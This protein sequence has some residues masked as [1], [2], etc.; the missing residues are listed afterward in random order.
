VERG[1]WKPE[2]DAQTDDQEDP[3]SP[4]TSRVIPYVEDTR[5]CLLIEPAE[6]LAEGQMASLQAALKNAIQ[7]RYQL[8]DNELAAE[9]LPTYEDRR[10]LLLYESAEGGAGV[11]RRLID[12]P[13][14]L[15]AVAG[16]AL[17]ICHF[18]PDGT[19][20]RRAPRAKEDC[21]AACYDCLM[22]YYNQGEHRILDR[23]LIRDELLRLAGAVTVESPASAPRASHLEQLAQQAES[24]LERRWLRYLDERGHRLPSHAQLLIEAAQTRPDFV[25]RDEQVAVY[26]DGPVHD[27]PERRERDRTKAEWLE[28]LGYTV[29]RFGHADEWANLLQRYPHVFGAPQYL[30]R[31]LATPDVKR[32]EQTASLDPDLFAPEYIPLLEAIAAALPDAVIE[33]GGDVIS[34]GRVAGSYFAEVISGDIKLRLIT[35]SAADSAIIKDA[36]TASGVRAILVEP[37]DLEGTIETIKRALEIK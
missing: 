7:V 11:L 32:T 17:E 10:L 20:K 24:D 21:E 22:S 12:D 29:I 36:I 2:A 26:I 31:P 14:A 33:P 18:E 1:Y 6:Q 5:N 8:E 16:K 23:K 3:L 4:R 15:A 35:N 28:D 9:P 19:D 13:H 27:F 37:R 34:D 25:Y 30:G